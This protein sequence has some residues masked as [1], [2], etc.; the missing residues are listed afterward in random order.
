MN[1]VLIPCM[2]T[3]QSVQG[4][5]PGPASGISYTVIVQYKDN[6]AFRSFTTAGVQPP[7]Q[8]RWADP[9]IVRAAPVNSQWQGQ[10]VNANLQAFIVEER[11]WV[12]C[13]G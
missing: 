6:G 13:A 4:T 8:T 1:G 5:T 2:V 7:V 3:V 9:W 11:D 10:I 12:E